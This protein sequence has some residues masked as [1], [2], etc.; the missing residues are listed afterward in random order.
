MQSIKVI[1]FVHVKLSLK[2]IPLA[3]LRQHHIKSHRHW[4]KSV[5]E[6][7]ANRSCFLLDLWPSAKVKTTV[8]WYKMVEANGAYKHGRNER[9][10]LKGLPWK[11]VCWLAGQTNTTNSIIWINKPIFTLTAIKT[12]SIFC[13]LKTL[14]YNKSTESPGPSRYACN[15]NNHSLTF[16][17]F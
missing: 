3:T 7:T 5:Q 10:C 14:S 11:T 1:S 17:V 6:N 2:Q 4:L 15:Q 13:I 8:K 16:L 12:W 9:I